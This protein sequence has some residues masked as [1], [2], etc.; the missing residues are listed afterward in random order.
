MMAWRWIAGVLAALVLSGAAFATEP[1]SIE[2]FRAA[3]IAA[4][5]EASP[6]VQVE[7]VSSFTLAVTPQGGTAS[8]VILDNV[9]SEYRRSP[10]A[11]QDLIGRHVRLILTEPTAGQQVNQG[12][13]VLL[14]R[15]QA[16][17][18]EA[19]QTAAATLITRPFA[20][21][22]VLVLALNRPESF[23]M[24]P[25]ADIRRAITTDERMLWRIAIANTRRL[26]GR[27][28]FTPVEGVEGV[29]YLQPAESLGPSVLLDEA[30]WG[31]PQIRALGPEVVVLLLRSGVVL[32][33]AANAA[34]LEMMQRMSQATADELPLLSP[35]LFVRGRR[36]AWS[37]HAPR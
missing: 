23:H 36:G 37:V 33:G 5:N 32:T 28:E 22:M 3:Y 18:S 24:P 29:L 12:D 21:D 14:V 1:E 11:R 19:Q 30:L 27:Y 25:A 16:Y 20:G 34:G 6:G 17:V 13:L 35:Q 2:D 4:L 8:T 26:A 9:Y 10:G 15:S 31:R 7:V